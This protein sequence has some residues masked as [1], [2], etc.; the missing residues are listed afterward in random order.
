[1]LLLTQDG[2]CPPKLALDPELLFQR[3]STCLSLNVL[4]DRASIV[5]VVSFL[6]FIERTRFID[7][8]HGGT[9]I[10]QL[11]TSLDDYGSIINIH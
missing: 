7:I 3:F 4:V 11:N 10:Q 1:M 6:N 5:C 2:A 8:H 9:Q